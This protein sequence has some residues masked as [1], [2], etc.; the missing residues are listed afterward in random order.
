M[1]SSFQKFTFLTITQ[2][3]TPVNF[4]PNTRIQF[5][6]A[7]HIARVEF[8]Q[9][10][11]TQSSPTSPSPWAAPPKIDFSHN[12]PTFDPCQLFTRHTYPV[13]I[14]QPHSQGSVLSEK[15]YIT[16]PNLPL[17]MGSSPE[18]LTSS[19]I[20]QPSTPANFLP[21]RPSQFIFANHITRVE[22]SQKNFTQPS[23]TSPPPWAAPSKIDFFHNYPTFD[24]CHFFT[25]HTYPVHICQPHSQGSVFSEKFHTT[26][27]N[28]SLS[29]GS[30]P[31]KLTFFRIT[32]PL[33]LATF[34]PTD[35]ASSY[36]PTT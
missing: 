35:L 24:P 11:L 29:M 30:S 5:I 10:N 19:R 16:L 9:K 1:G 18:K 3:L 2:P 26:L 25:Q 17:Y 7:N 28:L 34:Y 36:L 31:E 23:P 32:Q 20:T 22:F 12:Y 27:P 14:C 6:F 13:H 21:N 33:I 8:S 15:F 4:L